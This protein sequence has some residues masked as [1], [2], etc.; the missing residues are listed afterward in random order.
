MKITTKWKK[1]PKTTYSVSSCGEVRNDTT[2]KIL[3]QQLRN[4]YLAVRLNKKL[5]N[6]HRLV[7]EAFIQNPN[8]LP[9]VNHKSEVKTENFVENLEWC[10]HGYNCNYGKRNRKIGDKRK[11]ETLCIFPDGTTKTYEG[12][13]DAARELGLVEESVHTSIRQ[14]SSL[15][16][17]RFSYV[18]DNK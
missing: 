11:K 1:I 3:R 6:V 5:Y 2:G 4:G 8:N 18:P 12:A 13:V 16:G 10:T 9:C 7:A 15:Y 17:Y 14:G